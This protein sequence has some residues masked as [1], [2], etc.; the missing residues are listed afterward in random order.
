MPPQKGESMTTN[1][2]QAPEYATDQSS[3]PKSLHFNDTLFAG[4]DKSLAQAKKYIRY[5]QLNRE[6]TD[7]TLRTKFYH[8]S[9]FVRDNKIDDFCRLTNMQVDEWR[10]SKLESGA[11][12]K[13]I[14]NHVDDATGCVRYLKEKRMLT[15]AL[16]LDGVDRY[17]IRYDNEDLPSFTAEEITLIKQ[18]CKGILEEL[19]F[20]LTFDTAMRLHEVTYLQVEDIRHVPPT[21]NNMY[22]R[23]TGKGRVRRNTFILP[24]TQGLL[25]KWLLLTGIE[26]GYIFPSPVRDGLPY[27]NNQM[28]KIL[29]RPIRRAG[30]DAGSAHAV[31]RSAITIALDNGLSLP[32][33]AKWAGHTD[34]RITNKH[35]YKPDVQR[36]REEHQA[37][38][39]KAFSAI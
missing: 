28:R 34:P 16:N 19:V 10:A 20:S 36:L 5:C 18:H 21:N 31:R 38:L 4:H 8:L 37:A 27:T 7:D 11:S 17:R 39:E 25:N 2:I 33:A 22:L 32:R 12:K 13:T 1:L 30:F 3:N 6:F 29:S 24:E 35:Y 15:V 26:M 9:K 23:I 14:N